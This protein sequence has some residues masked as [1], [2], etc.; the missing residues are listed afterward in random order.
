[1]RGEA[2]MYNENDYAELWNEMDEMLIQYPEL[3]ELWL[4][5][6]KLA[7]LR[8]RY[9][10]KEELKDYFRKR[11]FTA[12]VMERVFRMFEATNEG[13]VEAEGITLDNPEL[14]RIWNEDVK[15]EYSDFPEFIQF[16]EESVFTDERGMS[17]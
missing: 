15:D 2:R 10:S 17:R 5:R 16:V 11:A 13:E 3:S 9:P 12:L 6:G 7:T 4:D 1:M 14:Y 8:T